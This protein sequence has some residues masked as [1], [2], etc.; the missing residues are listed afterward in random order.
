MNSMTETVRT[1]QPQRV[2]PIFPPY[3]HAVLPTVSPELWNVQ[4][5]EGPTCGIVAASNA[6]NIVRHGQAHYTRD[7]LL[8]T[9]HGWISHKYGS[10]S[11]TTEMIL[12]R[13]GAGTHFGNLR[14]TRAEDVLRQLI[15]MNIPVCIEL[16]QNKIGVVPIYGV[17]TIVL[18]GYSDSYTDAWGRTKEEYYFVDSAYRPDGFWSIQ[19]N[20]VDRNG[21][22]M[23]ETYPGNRT[24]TRQEFIQR[25][26]TGIY[27]PVFP[28]QADHD[29]WYRKALYSKKSF[30]ILGWIRNQFI[31]GTNDQLY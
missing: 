16:D 19:S 6:L 22:G 10:A 12:R 9:A 5:Q 4:E 23:A 2:K 27:F 3:V 17:H 21:D 14:F 29:T 25:F 26:P 28:T 18:V 20:N 30:P 11:F 8:S 31:T 13:H 15:D 7:Q 1:L 24:I